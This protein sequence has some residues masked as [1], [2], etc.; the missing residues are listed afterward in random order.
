MNEWL[1]DLPRRMALRRR[2]QL[3]RALA[4]LC[5]TTGET[6]QLDYLVVIERPSHY[7]ARCRVGDG[8]WEERTVPLD[9]VD[10]N[11]DAT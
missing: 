8:Q 4:W 10:G 7:R 2:R 5:D 6:V 9:V 11:W 1:D 3:E